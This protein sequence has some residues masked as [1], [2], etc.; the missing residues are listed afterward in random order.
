MKRGEENM[1]Q[2]RPMNKVK[3]GIL[4]ASIGGGVG[5]LLGVFNLVTYRRSGYMPYGIDYVMYVLAIFSIIGGIISF[6]GGMVGKNN[7]RAGGIIAIIGSVVSGINIITLIGG[8]FLYKGNPFERPQGSQW[9]VPP[10]EEARWNASGVKRC[11]ICNAQMPMEARFCPS[12]GEP[13]GGV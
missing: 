8:I 4:M 2:P 11:P 13:F 5:A 9:S 7:S 6:I 3:T 12:C 1:S 10:A